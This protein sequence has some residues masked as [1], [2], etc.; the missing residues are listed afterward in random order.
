MGCKGSRSYGHVIIMTVE[1]IH[2]F[3]TIKPLNLLNSVANEQYGNVPV[4]CSYGPYQ[5]GK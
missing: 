1:N 2:N 3:T 4:I 5:A